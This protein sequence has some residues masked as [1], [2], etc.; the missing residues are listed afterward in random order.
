MAYR[1]SRRH[2]DEINAGIG[3]GAGSPYTCWEGT[4]MCIGDVC[5][6]Y[7]YVCTTQGGCHWRIGPWFGGAIPGGSTAPTRRGATPGRGLT[8]AKTAS[9][10]TRRGR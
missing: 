4:D 5:G 6:C 8:L 3:V 9:R 1:P 7:K 10:F 2:Q